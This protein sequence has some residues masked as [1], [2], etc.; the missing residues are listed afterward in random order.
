MDNRMNGK[1]KQGEVKNL[2]QIGTYRGEV[3]SNG[4]ASGFGIWK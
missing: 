1:S 3:D 4:N 2:R